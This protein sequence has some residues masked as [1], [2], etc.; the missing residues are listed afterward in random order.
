[1]FVGPDHPMFGDNGIGSRPSFM[2]GPGGRPPFLPPGAVPPGARFDPIGP[3]GG[4]PGR[5]PGRGGRGGFGMGG[6]GG[7]GGPGGFRADPDNDEFLPPG[8]YEDMYG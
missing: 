1:M 2:G 4:P 7:M 3:F 6:R 8:N 5:F